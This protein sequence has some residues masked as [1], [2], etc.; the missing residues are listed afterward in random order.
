[1]KEK[2]SE[3]RIYSMFFIQ[4]LSKITTAVDIYSLGMVTLEV[5]LIK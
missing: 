1:M 2:K 5:C 4:E 3:S